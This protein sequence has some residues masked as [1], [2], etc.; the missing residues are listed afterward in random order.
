MNHVARP[1]SAEQWPHLVGPEDVI[2]LDM[3]AHSATRAD[4]AARLGCS[5]ATVDRRIERLKAALGVAT[6]IQVVTQA[7]R[8]G[9]I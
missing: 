6:L 9:L 7:V 1:T 3:F 2:L 5:P 8:D 4:V